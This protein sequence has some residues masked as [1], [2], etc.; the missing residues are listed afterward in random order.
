M[1]GFPWLDVEFMSC[2]GSR[3]DVKSGIVADTTKQVVVALE[4]PSKSTV[5]VVLNEAERVR[6]SVFENLAEQ[7]LLQ[8]CCETDIK[9]MYKGRSVR[10]HT[11]AVQLGLQCGDTL[12]MA[13][14]APLM[15][16]GLVGAARR[17]NLGVVRF[18]LDVKC[19][20]NQV[21]RDGMSAINA[22]RQQNETDIV[23]V[24]LAAR[25][26]LEGIGKEGSGA[27]ND[28]QWAPPRATQ[29]RSSRGQ[30]VKEGRRTIHI[31]AQEGDIAALETLVK[32]EA[33]LNQ[34]S[35]VSGATPAYLAAE[36]NQVEVLKLL[37]DSKA[38]VNDTQAGATPAYIAAQN[39]N[40]EALEVLCCAKADMNKE[41]KNGYTPLYTAAKHNSIEVL[42]LLLMKRA[43]VTRA[44]PQKGGP[45]KRPNLNR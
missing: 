12:V 28:W 11:T 30:K 6:L 21:D 41:S 16:Q 3:D 2:C 27:R 35:E 8:D 7:K 24:L 19:D 31:A 26:S 36:S 15:K 45:S 23:Q 5:E 43:D 20:A 34:P 37:L 13:E 1:F 40:T 44:K 22:A 10:T 29:G 32:S 33:D 14:R 18:L 25:A 38:D 42:S 9:L 39:N 4:F 17:G